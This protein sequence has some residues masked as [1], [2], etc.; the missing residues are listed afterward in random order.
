MKT[1]VS[2]WLS[3]AYADG[4]RS[5]I[6]EEAVLPTPT[7]ANNGGTVYLCAATRKAI[8]SRISRATSTASARGIVI[9]GRGIALSDRGSNFSMDRSS[10]KLRRP[11]ARN[12]TIRLSP[13]S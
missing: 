2:Y 9:P 6:G 7:D 8:W 10:G 3:D 1:D 11:R 12:R 5:L 4:R 13:A